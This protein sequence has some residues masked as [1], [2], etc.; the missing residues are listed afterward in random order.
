MWVHILVI[1]WV[2]AGQVNAAN[3]RYPISGAGQRPAA[4]P[5]DNRGGNSP[6][7]AP[8]VGSPG[9]GDVVPPESARGAA[10]IGDPYSGQNQPATRGQ[11]SYPLG[12]FSSPPPP[13]PPPFDFQA[14]PHSTTGDAVGGQPAGAT[15]PATL[16]RSMLTPP[17][18]SQL[19]G[20]R[21]SLAD[22]IS[23]AAT[24]AEQ[25][26]RVGAYWELCSG[27]ADYYL[28]LGERQDLRRVES[29]ARGGGAEW[30]QA[31]AELAVRLD[32]S[33]RAARASQ[34]RLAVWLG[35]GAPALPA[36]A[37]HCGSYHTRYEEIFAGRPSAEAEE[38][39][40]LL[41]LCYAELKDAAAAVKR[42][43]QSFPTAGGNAAARNTAA[44]AT[45]ALRALEVLSLR[46]RAFIQIA[47]DYNHRI[48]RYTE[49]ASPGEVG[50]G[51]LIG[52]LIKTDSSSTATRPASGAAIGRQSSNSSNV[53]PRTFA[54][55]GWEPAG[56][57]TGITQRDE[58][59]RP[60]SGELRQSPRRERSLLVSPR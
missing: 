12:N 21:V 56:E 50:A 30:Q 39:A 51:R 34:L 60:A 18:D 26:Q 46:R 45:G 5:S 22:V 10:G 17:G 13:A 2:V 29:M 9:Q 24:R 37:P 38:L 49:L 19:P 35:R 40:Q 7:L 44:D 25:S 4:N 11:R 27:V 28:A 15:T 52:M 32:T 33:L 48:A 57:G 55:E 59:V 36:D 8:L 6:G 43:E 42:A 3:D 47:R 23:G 16:M 53:P 1:G 14:P 20:D 31:E 58:A 41:P 54:E